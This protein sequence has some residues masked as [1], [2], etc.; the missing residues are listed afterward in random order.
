MINFIKQCEVNLPNQHP[1][2]MTFCYPGGDNDALFNSPADWISP[3]NRTPESPLTADGRKVML[4]DSD[5]LPY[6]RRDRA[7]VW[8]SFTRGLNPIFMDPVEMPQWESVRQA[9]GMTLA[10][11]NRMDLAG[12]TPRGELTS[13]GYCLA[14]PGA[15]SIPCM[16]HSRFRSWNR[17]ASFAG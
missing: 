2:G 12:M 10:Y 15:E 16:R 1:V 17:C 13:T 14:K 5:H 7:W 3:S 11:A 6:L 4:W 9:M 8:K